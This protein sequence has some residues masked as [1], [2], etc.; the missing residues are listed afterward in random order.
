[1]CSVHPDRQFVTFIRHYDMVSYW[2]K[3]P[4]QHMPKHGHLWRSSPNDGIR[5]QNRVP[6]GLG[7]SLS[8]QGRPLPVL[9]MREGEED[10][11]GK[12]V[13]RAL[14]L[15]REDFS[16]SRNGSGGCESE[17]EG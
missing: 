14:V 16:H 9:S 8:C 10:E 1:M 2:T 3:L 11:E 4:C 13:I 7:R 12:E 5:L 15:Y 6:Q 17:W